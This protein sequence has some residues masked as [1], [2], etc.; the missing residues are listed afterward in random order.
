M[1][2]DIL[3]V[4]QP[5]A[6]PQELERVLEAAQP[7]GELPAAT[8][9]ANLTLSVSLARSLAL[10][11]VCLRVCLSLTPELTLTL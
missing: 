4:T 3:V 5:A 1:D 8:A 9:Q 10:S 11:S 7:L 6:L 2:E